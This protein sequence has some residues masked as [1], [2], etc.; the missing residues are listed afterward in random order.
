MRQELRGHSL[1]G[2]LVRAGEG[3][4]AR[5]WRWWRE[6]VGASESKGQDDA[7][8]GQLNGRKDWSEECDEDSAAFCL[9]DL[10][11]MASAHC[12]TPHPTGRAALG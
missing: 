12:P 9:E 2:V 5:K 10:Q 8:E 11:E 1:A 6:G 4:E 3:R 7:L